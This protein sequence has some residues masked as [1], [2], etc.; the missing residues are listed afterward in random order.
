MILSRQF[1]ANFAS[2]TPE[3]ISKIKSREKGKKKLRKKLQ[4]S[5]SVVK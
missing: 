2:A 5:N 1:G 3:K 4:L